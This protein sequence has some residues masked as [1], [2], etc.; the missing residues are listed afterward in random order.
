MTDHPPAIQGARAARAGQPLTSNPYAK[1][2]A[3]PTGD[4]YPGDWANW[5]GGW[6]TETGI[7]AR[8]KK[9][10]ARHGKA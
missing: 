6:I 8:D 5:R 4:E 2:E 3:L 7:I 9:L 1:P 10:G